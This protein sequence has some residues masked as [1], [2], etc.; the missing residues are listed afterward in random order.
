LQTHA[1][2]TWSICQSYTKE[3]CGIDAFS[4]PLGNMVYLCS[5]GVWIALSVVKV[6]LTSVVWWYCDVEKWATW[7][8]LSSPK[9][10]VEHNAWWKCGKRL[11]HDNGFTINNFIWISLF[12]CTFCLRWS[13]TNSFQNISLV[14]VNVHAC[15]TLRNY[16]LQNLRFS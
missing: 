12:I 15:Q 13:F 5:G 3:N 1:S 11:M 6:N 7:W 4:M 14:L 16:M 9:N 2:S 10:M 8:W